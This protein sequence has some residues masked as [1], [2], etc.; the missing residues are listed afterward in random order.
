MSLATYLKSKLIPADI[1][2]HINRIRKPI[3]S[4][5]YDPWGYNNEAIKYGFA[6]TRQIY[7]KYFRVE[8]H[9]VEQVP[10]EGPVLIIANHSGQLPID[11]LLIGYAL[12][13][14]PEQPRIPRAM[15]ERFFPTVPW[16]GNLLNEMGAVLGD[17]VNCA[18]MLANNE[19]VIVFPEG[20]R[21]SGKLYKDRYQLKRFG[22]GFMHLAM[23]YNAPIVPVGVVG[24]EET[25]PAIANIKPLAKALGIP[26]APVALPAV[27]PAKVHL[28]F[29]AP[30]YFDNT[31]IPEELVTERVETV[32]A[33]ISRLIDKGLSERKKLF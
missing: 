15:I 14:R 8:A 33:E 5:G 4:L 11:G 27:L 21:G 16:L 26:Y 7:E 3:G 6:L 32:K 20:I 17:P 22:N 29:G 19:A 12:A 2:K 28:N 30:M 18:K 31:E 1:D 24:C 23:K 13:S 10:A 9:G 25:I